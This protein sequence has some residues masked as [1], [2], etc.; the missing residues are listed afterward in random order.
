V[1]VNLCLE[2]EVI[3]LELALSNHQHNRASDSNN[4]NC[5][6]SLYY[7]DNNHNLQ[8]LV[9][10]LNHQLNK[11]TQVLV[12][13]LQLNLGKLYNFRINSNNSSSNSNSSSNNKHWHLAY[14]WIQNMLLM[15]HMEWQ[16]YQTMTFSRK[17]S[18]NF[19][20][21]RKRPIWQSL[22]LK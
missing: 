18:K 15:I 9:S 6:P 16:L 8:C 2:V 17:R 7:L 3:C 13:N 5:Q 22:T 12:N 14:S 19:R 10:K 1:V 4:S 21:S 11:P 20:I